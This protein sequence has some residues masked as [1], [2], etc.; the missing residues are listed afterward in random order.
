MH[1]T[2]YK[3]QPMI[4]RTVARQILS[5]QS[6]AHDRKCQSLPVA[7]GRMLPL[8]AT[9]PLRHIRK[10]IEARLRREKHE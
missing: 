8:M 9:D 5:G 3:L 2:V 4:L 6:G 7:T 10:A 1:A